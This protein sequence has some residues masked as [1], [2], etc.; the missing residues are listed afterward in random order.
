M[1]TLLIFLIFFLFTYFVYFPLLIVYSFAL[2]FFD[3][4]VSSSSSSFSG[5]SHPALHCASALGSSPPVRPRT[6]LGGVLTLSTRGRQP[7]GP[8]GGGGPGTHHPSEAGLCWPNLSRP[9]TGHWARL[10]TENG[11][12]ATHG[13]TSWHLLCVSHRCCGHW[14][15]SNPTP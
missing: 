13:S 15:R 1:K 10:R 4:Q 14:S 9:R 8:A 11:Q 6:S 2:L 5:G 12:H 3:V 7:G